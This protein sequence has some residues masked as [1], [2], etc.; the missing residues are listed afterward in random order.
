MSNVEIGEKRLHLPLIQGGMGVGVSLS[1]LAGN[2]AKCGA[3]GVISSA[4]IGF[5]ES[6]F[7]DHTKEANRRAILQEVKKAKEIAEGHGLIGM[8]IMVALRDYKQHVQAA[9]EA[10]V[11]CIISGAGLPLSLPSLVKDTPVKIAPV[12]SSS[13]ACE[14]I[15]KSWHRKY[16]RVA[17]FIVIEG[18]LAGGHLGFSFENIQ[19]KST[20]KLFDILSDVKAVIR[21]YEELYHHKIPVFVAGGIYTNDDIKQALRA[22]ADGVQMATRFIATDECDA[23]DGFKQ[24]FIH[25]SK[26]DLML[27]KSPVGMPARALSTPFLKKHQP[28]TKCFG[29]IQS[30]HMT[31]ASYCITEALINAVN[32]HIDDGIV[33]SG[34]NGYRLDKI[35]SVKTLIDELMEGIV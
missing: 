4:Q 8:N 31:N 20:Q 25:A 13:K 33:F 21:K 26:D 18:S 24:A 7:A 15:L 29:C 28:I 14:V 11:D 35:V 17:D 16:Q 3:M 9:I 22:G 5:R 12:V 10:G 2:V 19:N 34:T 32:G 6:N 30:C 1:R 27:I 23:S